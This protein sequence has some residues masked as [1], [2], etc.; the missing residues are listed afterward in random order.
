M[1]S[2]HGCPC[3]SHTRERTMYKILTKDFREKINRGIDQNIEELLRCD[4]NSLVI[5]EINAYQMLRNMINS[6]PDGCPIPVEKRG[7]REEE[8][9]D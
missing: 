4:K 2:S 7:Q 8:Q 3:Q 1:R 5:A 9:N 6:L